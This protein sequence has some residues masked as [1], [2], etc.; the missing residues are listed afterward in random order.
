MTK[1]LPEQV[2]QRSFIKGH[3]FPNSLY[4]HK[5][6]EYHYTS[7][8]HQRYSQVWKSNVGLAEPLKND[9]APLQQHTMAKHFKFPP[10]TMSLFSFYIVKKLFTKSEV[11]TIFDQKMAIMYKIIWCNKFLSLQYYVSMFLAFLKLPSKITIH[12]LD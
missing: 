11:S 7:V 6:L 5:T 4:K 8:R 10:K 1:K 3:S 9:V 12:F 2:V